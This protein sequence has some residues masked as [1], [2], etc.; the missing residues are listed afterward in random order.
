MCK[1]LARA[2]LSWRVRCQDAHLTT[3]KQL[4]KANV[5]LFNTV[6]INFY[7]IYFTP[8]VPQLFKLKNKSRYDVFGHSYDENIIFTPLNFE[9]KPLT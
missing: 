1:Q 6:I 7:P 2:C 3:Y 5:L 9:L 4:T 8:T